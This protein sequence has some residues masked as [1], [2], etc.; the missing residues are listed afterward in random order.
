MFTHCIIPYRVYYTVIECLAFIYNISTDRLSHLALF[1]QI[2]TPYSL[3]LG[4]LFLKSYAT[5]STKAKRADV[6][7]TRHSKYNNYAFIIAEPNISDRLHC[8]AS[9][10]NTV[11]MIN[12]KVTMKIL[13]I[14]YIR[15]ISI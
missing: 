14:C 12:D 9:M 10:P 13:K 5:D 1:E 11:A 4:L 3:P 7:F 8:G 15:F 6:T 2:R